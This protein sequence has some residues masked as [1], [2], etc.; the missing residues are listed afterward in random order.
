MRALID[1]VFRKSMM[2]RFDL[3]LK[4][5]GDASGKKILDIG[6]GPRRIVVELTRRGT[7]VVG[8]DF[9]QKMID[10]ADSLSKK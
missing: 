7:Y 10:L 8:I 2:E 9:S 3:T 5:C 6:C 1:K 4:E